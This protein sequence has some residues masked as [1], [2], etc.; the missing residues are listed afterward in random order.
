MNITLDEIRERPTVTVPEAGSFLGLGRD[1]S[2]RAA[3][4]GEIPTLR[5]GRRLVV[6]V[7]RLLTLLGYEPA[8]EEG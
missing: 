3:E 5:F 1:A 8:I 7:P 2:Y 6:P 4:A